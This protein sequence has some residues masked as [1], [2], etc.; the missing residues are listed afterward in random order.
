MGKELKFWSYLAAHK[1][2]LGSGPHTG[3]QVTGTEEPT[4]SLPTPR[5]GHL[6]D[7]A[8]SLAL[9]PGWQVLRSPVPSPL[10]PP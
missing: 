7:M 6:S 1:D 10:L 2:G 9:S 4:F 5:K 8:Q 3:V